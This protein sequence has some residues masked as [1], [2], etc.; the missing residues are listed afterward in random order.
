MRQVPSLFLSYVRSVAVVEFQDGAVTTTTCRA[1][2]IDDRRDGWN[3]GTATA[4][5]ALTVVR[6]SIPAMA[7]TRVRTLMRPHYVEVYC[8]SGSPAWDQPVV[9]DSSS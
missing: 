3:S 9:P 2:P 5:A 6:S 7:A 8:T 1:S 4:G